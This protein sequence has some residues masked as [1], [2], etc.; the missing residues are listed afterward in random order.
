VKNLSALESTVL[1]GLNQGTEVNAMWKQVLDES[2]FDSLPHSINRA[3]PTLF[4]TLDGNSD[5]AQYK[6][7]AGITK[8]NWAENMMRAQRLV[9]LLRAAEEKGIKVVILKGLAI[10]FL[11][12]DF[13]SRVMGDTD[14]L[15]K[16]RD[17]EE[18]LKILL[19]LG[20]EPRYRR[21]C[22]HRELNRNVFTNAFVDSSGNIIDV[23][24]IESGNFFFKEIWD[25]SQS[26]Y[27]QG[28]AVKI[29]QDSH[30]LLHSLQHGFHGVASSDLMQTT[31]DF[32]ALK[33]RIDVN[34]LVM[35]SVQ[36]GMYKKLSL[37]AEFLEIQIPTV[38]GKPPVT[39]KSLRKVL[40]KFLGVRKD[41]EISLKMAFRASKNPDLRRLRY[42]IWILLSAPRPLEQM[43]IERDLG[44]ITN[45][46]LAGKQSLARS[47]NSFKPTTK[48]HYEIRFGVEGD[49]QNMTIDS[50]G[51]LFSPHL[52]FI[53]GK[54][55]GII[56]PESLLITSFESSRSLRYEI[57]IRQPY[58]RCHS[59]SEILENSIIS[60]Q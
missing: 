54:L 22:T 6:R 35:E 47:I 33:N 21:S 30:I 28:L 15:I 24:T 14:L 46:H 23:H 9:P 1:L 50:R 36:W 57:S 8:K 16:K 60:F 26:I 52:L 31:L 45:F 10:S 27:F 3:L 25:N 51:H 29:P 55:A 19:S 4:K 7:L 37:L 18:I 42:L 49:F 48:E 41:R 12:N 53:N 32:I 56:E 2:E 58:G 40:S 13:S 5:V 11:T 38:L 44:F 20:F 39:R 17:Q 34:K 43:I 59:C